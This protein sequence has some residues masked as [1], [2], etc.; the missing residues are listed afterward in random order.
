MP[1]RDG[2]ARRGRRALRHLASCTSCAGASAAA[3]TPRCACSSARRSRARLRALAEHRDGFKLAEIDLELRGE[4]E[5]LGTRQ[6]GLRGVPVRAAAR[7]RRAARARPR[8]ARRALLD[9]DPASPRPS[10]RCWPRARRAAAPRRSS[11]SPREDRRRPLRGPAAVRAPRGRATRPTSDRVREALFSILGERVAGAHVLDLFAGSG[12]LGLEALSRGAAAATFVDGAQAAIRAVSATSRRSRRRPRCA[13][14]TRC[15]SSRGARGKAA[16]TISSSST[17]PTGW[18]S[19]S[20]GPLSEAL[21]AVL[22]PERA[23]WSPR[24]TAG[25]R[26]P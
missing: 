6:S 8:C 24:A 4:G 15:G 19:A 11:R 12:A 20:G 18:P 2:D 25:H 10:T 5:M 7:G 26:W 1:E 17:R 3:S 9:A 23:W 22:A 21:P 16:T 13:A 14:R